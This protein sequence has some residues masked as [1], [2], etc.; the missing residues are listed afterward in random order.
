MA[1][2]RRPEDPLEAARTEAYLGDALRDVALLRGEAKQLCDALRHHASACDVLG[3]KSREI[4]CGKTLNADRSALRDFSRSH[5]DAFNPDA[6]CSAVVP[7]TYL[8]KVGG[9]AR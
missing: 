3:Q 7:T 6:E 2:A 5:N 1:Q 9:G 8:E 4:D